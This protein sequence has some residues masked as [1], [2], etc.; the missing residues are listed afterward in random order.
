RAVRPDDGDA[1]VAADAQ[2]AGAHDGRLVAGLER[3]RLQHRFAAEVG[4][5][6]A[7]GVTRRLRRRLDALETR[8]LLPAAAGLLRSL[9][10]AIAADEVLGPFDLYRLTRRRCLLR[11]LAV[12]ALTRVVRVRAAVLD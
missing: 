8:E 2:R 12:R 1:R 4:R 5:L 9:T 3:S 11:R 10:C 6:K 7:P